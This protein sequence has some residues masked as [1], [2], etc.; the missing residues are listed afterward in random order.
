[1]LKITISAQGLDSLYLSKSF[2][3]EELNQVL[4]ELGKEFE[5][6]F[7]YKPEWVEGMYYSGNINGKSLDQALN[8]ILSE[9]GLIYTVFQN[10]IVLLP[11]KEVA[12]IMG[13]MVDLN[14][15]KKMDDNLIRIGDASLVGKY[16]KVMLSGSIK[17]GATS[18][19]LTGA[20]ILVE[21]SNNYSVSGYDGSFNLEMAPG[22]YTLSA[23]CIGYE[24]KKIDIEI[25]SP[26]KLEVELFEKTHKINEI[27]VYAQKADQNIRSHQMSVV[28]LDSKTI[29][30]LP[31]MVGDKDIIKSLTMMPG[32][33]SVGEFGSGINVRG[34]GEDQNLYLIEDAPV[35]NT[36]HLM[37]LLSVVNPD[38][39]HNVTLYKGHI[40]AKYG[41]RVSSVMDIELQDYNGKEFHVRGGIGLYSSRL[42]VEGP[43]INKKVSYKIAGRTSYSNL[44]L[45]QMPDYYLQNS[46]ANFYDLSAN[47]KLDLKNNPIKIFG[48][49]SYDYFKYAQDYL[50]DYG[51]KLGSFD[52]SHIFSGNLSSTLSFSYSN[53]NITRED[54]QEE[55]EQSSVYSETEYI[56][57]KFIL[58]Y[59]GFSGHKMEAGFQ[60][61]QYDINPGEQSPINNSK[62]SYFAT[63]PEKGNEFAFFANDIFELNER[64]TIQ[65]GL[66]YS[67]YNNYGPGTVYQ[68]TQEANTL[69]V[70]VDS[71]EY[72]AGEKIA[73]YNCLEP[74]VSLKLLLTETSS[75]KLSYNKNA[76]YI[77]LL[78][79]TSISTPEDVWKLSDT[80]I[81]PLISNQIAC[82]YYRNFFSNQL[83]TSIEL[84]YKRLENLLEYRNGAQL[85]L[86][87]QVEAEL[88]DADGYNYGVEFL[89]KKSAGKFNGWFSYTYS[90]ALKQTSG[91]NTIDQINNNA[92]YSSSYDKPHD[93][94]I[95]LNYQLNRRFRV[96]TNFALAS[97]RP[98]TLPEYVFKLGTQEV[99]YYSDR[100]KYR[101]PTYHRLDVFISLSESLKKKKKWKGNWTF[102]VLNVYGRKNAYS[103]FYKQEE[104]TE[105]NNYQMFSLYKMYLIGRP[106]PTITYNF[107]F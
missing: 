107:V 1:M 27:V 45:K 63:E 13:D 90:R 91:V 28:Q 100:N 6:H 34:G 10:Q 81:K 48:Y 18:E 101:L 14:H 7:Y 73:S 16:K 97:G 26:G 53:Y 3:D 35:L 106:L 82:G 37:G 85:S 4:S 31:G 88:L 98:V 23:S 50:Y 72:N 62:L 22:V 59:N 78:S 17:D 104:P 38:V 69:P 8:T 60:A 41:E 58:N 77:S 21:S 12:Y 102:S 40:P 92:I 24:N 103:V 84:Y 80:Y 11:Q 94:T 71:T 43:L 20:T 66:R 36:S 54:Y 46:S 25:F 89:V 30:Q 83:E 9:F 64:I 93:L 67:F 49:Y 2:N 15:E 42:M 105:E 61:I 74:R 29:D 39:V 87:N 70:V 44:L 47:M 79:Y 75:L 33:K 68:Y 52:W 56:S 99:V 19:S 86:N 5:L 32:V 65:A 57:G 96:G 51:N 95:Y 76:Q 55:L